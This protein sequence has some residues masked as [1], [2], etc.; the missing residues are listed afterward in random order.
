MFVIPVILMVV[1]SMVCVPL[2]QPVIMFVAL[3]PGMPAIIVFVVCTI[4]L[5]PVVVA[6]IVCILMVSAISLLMICIP[7]V[8]E[9]VTRYHSLLFL[10]FAP[11]A[12]ALERDKKVTRIIVIEIRAYVREVCLTMA[13]SL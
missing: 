4:F 8:S 11:S 5:I 7:M 6:F 2:I 10:C 3:I 1:T 9:I 13:L 12:K